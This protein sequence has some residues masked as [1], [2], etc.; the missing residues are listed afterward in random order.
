[1]NIFFKSSILIFISCIQL[2]AQD[3]YDRQKLEKEF[4]AMGL[5]VEVQRNKSGGILRSIL[6]NQGNDT[7]VNYNG[8]ELL[9]S[10][11]SL[12]Q[13]KSDYRYGIIKLTGESI[14]LTKFEMIHYLG[15][16]YFSC[17]YKGNNGLYSVEKDG[18]SISNMITFID[19]IINILFCIKIIKKIY[20]YSIIKEIP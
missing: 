13:T 18:C 4:N 6:L 12:V 1:M 14:L 7:L 2:N 16:G 5:R 10:G 11:D 19:G 9:Y 15:D 20:L 8:G 3:Y 17:Q